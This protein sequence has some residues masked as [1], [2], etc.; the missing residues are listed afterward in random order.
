MNDAEEKFIIKSG[1]QCTLIVAYRRQ[2]TLNTCK[3]GVKVHG[4]K[5][6]WNNLFPVRLASNYVEENT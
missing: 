2:K 3:L 5:R 6:W 1:I 4:Q